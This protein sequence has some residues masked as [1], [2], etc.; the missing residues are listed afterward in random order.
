MFV[1]FR[2]GENPNSAVWFRSKD[3]EEVLGPGYALVLTALEITNVPMTVGRLEGIL[4]WWFKSFFTGEKRRWLGDQAGADGESRRFGVYA[5]WP[6]AYRDT[7]APYGKTELFAP[8]PY[9]P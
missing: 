4:G 6:K 7:F 9:L 2:G 1:T 5:F 3:F 8:S